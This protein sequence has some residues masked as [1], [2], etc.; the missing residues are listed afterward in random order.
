MLS[1]LKTEKL[2]IVPPLEF[3]TIAE[4][5]KTHHPRRRESDRQI[6]PDFKTGSGEQGYDDISISIN[7]SVIQLLDPDFADRLFELV[8]RMR[9]EPKN[10][11]IEITESVFSS[12]FDHINNIIGKLKK[13]GFH[14]AMDDFGTG[15]SS[16]ARQ[17]EL[18]VDCMKIDKYFIDKLLETDLDKAITSDIISMAHKLGALHSCRGCGVRE[19]D[20]VP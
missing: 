18:H 5:D 6:L 15:Y 14:I 3:I 17:R 19:P 20:A 10:I 4:K 8:N 9:I 1:R 12:D 7:I 16:L 2:G 13:A 11:G